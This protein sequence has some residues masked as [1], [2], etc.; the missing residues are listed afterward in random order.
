MKNRRKILFLFVL[1]IGVVGSILFFTNQKRELTIDEIL[2]TD[3]YNYLS[4]NVKD[5][6]KE[7]YEETEEL[8]LTEKNFKDNEAY[9]NPSYI[10]YLDSTNKDSYS[11]IPSVTA[12]VPKLMAVNDN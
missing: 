1:I 10:E 12:Y 4:D 5:F 7:H 6:I 3:A 2:K 9:L 8:Y 11:I